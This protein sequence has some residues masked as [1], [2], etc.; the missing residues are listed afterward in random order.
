M[1]AAVCLAAATL[2]LQ[3]QAQSREGVLLLAHGGKAEWNA[4][5]T[6]LAA[7]LGTAGPVEVAF[8]MASR[9]SLQRAIETTP[10]T[11]VAATM[12]TTRRMSRHPLTPPRP[13]CLRC[14][15]A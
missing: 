10:P 14:R 7:G 5:V 8:G 6:D 9:A 13:W 11:V 1:A 3:A 15:F 2:A 12:G 4:H